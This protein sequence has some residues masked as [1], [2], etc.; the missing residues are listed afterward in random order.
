M[1]GP[2]SGLGARS[3][4]SWCARRLA[5]QVTA[6]LQEWWSPEVARRLRIEVLADPMMR[7]S[8]ETIYQ[9]P[10][11]QGGGELRRGLASGPPPVT[12]QVAYE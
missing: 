10:F 1:S 2:G 3:S 5:A 12:P 8:H 9:A 4:R 11:V 6:W 7:V